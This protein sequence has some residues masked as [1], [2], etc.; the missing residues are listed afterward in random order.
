MENLRVSK[1]ANRGEMSVILA[2]HGVGKSAFGDRKV[3]PNGDTGWYTCRCIECE[4]KF[5][6]KKGDNL[7][8]VCE[9][10]RPVQL[11]LFEDN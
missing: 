1:G 4:S 9:L 7:C 11:D 8:E 2:A 6:G 10:S 3:Y 5:I